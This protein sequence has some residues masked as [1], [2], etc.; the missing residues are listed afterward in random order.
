MTTVAVLPLE[1]Y[2]R[3]IE[4][5]L[6]TFVEVGEALL[7]IRDKRLYRESHATFEDYCR[8]RWG[9]TDRRARQLMEA[10]EIGTVVPV[11]N[12]A[13]ARELAPLRDDPEALAE[14]WEE[15]SSDGQPTAEKV[16][17]AVRARKPKP[18]TESSVPIRVTEWTR[19]LW[20]VK[21]LLEKGPEEF[22]PR[23][24]EERE[25]LLLTVE[26]LE[27]MTSTVKEI[28]HGKA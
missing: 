19:R 14:A 23:T 24:D 20:D 17:E 13:Q 21:C 22:V 9:F 7:A 15:A 27:A 6:A 11:G 18:E 8:E 5:G 2:E 25:S 12:E 16:R 4:R 1:E 26:W 3:T 10:S 28:L